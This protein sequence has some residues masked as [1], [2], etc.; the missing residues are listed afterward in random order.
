[1]SKDK[2]GFAR[3]LNA[4][5]DRP[6]GSLAEVPKRTRNDLL[7]VRVDR[8]RKIQC[9]VLHRAIGLSDNDVL[10]KPQAIPSTSRQVRSR[11]PTTRHQFPKTR[12]CLSLQET[13]A[14][15]KASVVKWW[16]AAFCTAGF[17]DFKR[18][19]NGRVGRYKINK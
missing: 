10:D 11:R 18:Y 1:M 2:N 15:W 8:P 17:F 13:A 4:K 6:T 7:H 9:H 12:H 19:A 16:P 14:A 3:P 5:S